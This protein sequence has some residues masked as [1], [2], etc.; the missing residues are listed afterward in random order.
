M[1]T[2]SL[3]PGELGPGTSVAT[4]TRRPKSVSSGCPLMA[5]SLTITAPPKGAPARAVEGGWR[6]MSMAYPMSSGDAECRFPLERPGVRPLC[7]CLDLAFLLL[8]ARGLATSAIE[9][10]I[11]GGAWSPL[12]SS[13]SVSCARRAERRS[14]E[15]RFW[16]RDEV[17]RRDCD[18]CEPTPLLDSLRAGLGFLPR[19]RPRPLCI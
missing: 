5:L 11:S 1:I 13:S 19:P 14:A 18:E 6:T 3:E 2:G 15:A 7:C 8:S 9:P 17:V 16:V 4:A 12:R 10:L